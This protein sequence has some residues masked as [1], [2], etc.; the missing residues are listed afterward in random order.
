VRSTESPDSLT[1]HRPLRRRIGTAVLGLLAACSTSPTRN[2]AEAP[3]TEPE[4]T[5]GRR[6]FD[7]V[8][9]TPTTPTTPA[10]PASSATAKSSTRVQ[11]PPPSRVRNW[12]ELG[13][14]AAER[15]VA[16]NPRGSYLGTV[17]ETLLAI[18]VLEIELDGD[19]NVRRIVVLRKPRQA[20]DTVQLAMDA[21]RSAAPYGDVSKLPKP[22][23]FTETFLFDDA[24]R[25]KPRSLD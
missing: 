3:A 12:S 23:R 8:T 10:G 13:R 7:A 1:P 16:A 21:V 24:R 17:P 22:W 11:L 4:P 2:G 9:T 19:G 5:S 15:M 18:P 6:S 20:L 14:Q 25:F